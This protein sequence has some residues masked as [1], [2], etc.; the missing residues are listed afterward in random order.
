[1]EITPLYVNVN[2]P[3]NLEPVHSQSPT[4]VFTGICHDVDLLA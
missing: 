1:M 3:L 2:M 4:Y